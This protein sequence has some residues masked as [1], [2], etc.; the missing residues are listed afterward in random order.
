VVVVAS[1]S[2]VYVG[3]E[4]VVTLES[5]AISVG[6]HDRLAA[7]FAR[8][9]AAGKAEPLQLLLDRDTAYETVVALLIDAKRKEAGITRFV[10][11]AGAD[12]GYVALPL[13]L[14]TKA[15]A[16]ARDYDA[17]PCGGAS[18]VTGRQPGSDLARAL[19]PSAE[20][21]APEA[22]TVGSIMPA[23]PARDLDCD[24]P[25]VSISKKDV[26][27]AS[28]RGHLGT[29]VEPALREARGA[30]GRY[31]FDAV[32]SRLRDHVATSWPDGT[33]RPSTARRIIVMLDGELPVQVLADAMRAVA[34]TDRAPL[35]PDIT[36]SVGMQ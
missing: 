36:L 28:V 14:P 24:V 6:P 29:F 2:A 8:I 18:V 25:I 27:V 35:F 26:M 9:A 1:P 16:S 23:P 21:D 20:H 5:G 3:D 10:I 12:G 22:A 19:D 34:G 32:T 33:P 4:K 30:A 13:E 31:P 7:A 11:I 17:D 15:S